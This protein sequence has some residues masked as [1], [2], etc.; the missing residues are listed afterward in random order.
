MKLA[1]TLVPLLP[2]TPTGS[3]TLKADHPRRIWELDET[4]HAA[5]QTSFRVQHGSKTELRSRFLGF[6]LDRRQF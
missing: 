2:L 3:M 1:E 6:V 4:Y 5:Q